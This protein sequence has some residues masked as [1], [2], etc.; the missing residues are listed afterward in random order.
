MSAQKPGIE[1]GIWIEQLT[2]LPNL[3]ATGGPSAPTP[4][5]PSPP[6]AS[7]PPDQSATFTLVCRAVNLNVISGD[8]SANQ[9][10]AYAVEN[11]LKS[12]TN[13][14]DPK[15]T[16]LTGSITPDDANGTFTFGVQVTLANPMKL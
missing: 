15:L 12:S 16:Q 4:P 10:V 1:A 8:A 14:F 2:A 5:P 9:E 7:A 3:G 6:G 13:Y 11:V